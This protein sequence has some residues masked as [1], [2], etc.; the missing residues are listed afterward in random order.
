MRS[1]L[2]S[3]SNR[4]HAH[5]VRATTRPEGVARSS[6]AAFTECVTTPTAPQ[7]QYKSPA[8]WGAMQPVSM[9]RGDYPRSARIQIR[10]HRQIVWPGL[11]MNAD[12]SLSAYPP[13]Q[14]QP[15][16]AE[17]HALIL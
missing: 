8:P 4:A 2:C 9:P 3:P 13:R 15:E 10:Q 14:P 16:L 6:G 17:Q 7:D 12:R 11:P 1:P 5:N